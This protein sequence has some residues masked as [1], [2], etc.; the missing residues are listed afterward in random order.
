MLMQIVIRNECGTVVVKEN[1]RNFEMLM[2][3]GMGI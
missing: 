2:F 1:N 3:C